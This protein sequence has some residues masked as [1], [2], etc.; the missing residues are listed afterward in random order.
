MQFRLRIN[1]FCFFVVLLL[2]HNLFNSSSILSARNPIKDDYLSKQ[3]WIGLKGAGFLTKASPVQRFSVFSSTTNAPASIYDKQYRNFKTLTG[4]GG[5]E[6]TFCYKSFCVS[7][8]PDFRRQ[9][10]IYT[11]TYSWADA[12][13]ANN[14][15]D[16][17]YKAEQ[18]LDYF[19]YP[20]LF[21]YNPLKT[22]FKFYVEG[23]AYYAYLN[24]AYKTTKV[25]ITDYASGG[26]KPYVA[27]D[28]TSG[29]KSLFIKSNVGWAAGAG[30]S[31]AL[32]NM[33]IAATADY[34]HNT[35]NITSV[36][37]RYAN[38]RLTGSGDVM[39]DIKLRTLSFSISCLVPLRFMQ[40]SNVTAE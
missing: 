25:T 32:G 16:A 31:Y 26:N 34:W 35:N 18:K 8:Q 33:R 37:N 22:K 12:Q 29:A 17:D 6:L 24:N 3:F 28:I 40:R 20:L 13:N 14:R 5:L 38:D 10:V 4:G 15:Y 7:F 30:V 2:T 23:G 27:Q 1:R 21:R 39:D 11:N 36:A 9:T 19:V